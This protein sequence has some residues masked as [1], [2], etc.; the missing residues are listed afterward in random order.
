MKNIREISKADL[1]DIIINEM[2]ESKYRAQQIYDWIWKKNVSRFEDM[3]NLS[4]SLQAALALR[5]FFR[6]LSI[7]SMQESVDGTVKYKFKTSDQHFIEG[8]LIPTEHR[9]TACISSQ[10][11]CSLSC[12]FCATG[13]MGHIRN[14]HF[15]EIYEQV[16]LINKEVEKKYG[17]K[18]TNLVLMGMGEPLLNYKEVL[19]AINYITQPDAFAMSP[20]RITLSTAGIAKMI[21]Q[22][23]DD[24]VRFK[25][26]LSLHAANDVKR[27]QLMPINE[28]NNLKT[29]A[30]ALNYFYQQTKGEITLEYTL[31]QNFNDTVKDA[32]ELVKFY[33]TVP[34]D[35]INIIEYNTI[36]NG[37]FQP[38]SEDTLE[39]FV[40]I[41]SKQQVNV[42]VRR[43][44]GKDIAAACGQLVV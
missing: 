20:R 19:K 29:L 2:G 21:K 31:L 44:R 1:N 26:A 22:L 25:L 14:L 37:I 3:T 38:S 30:T 15:D 16:A 34:V 42:R 33:R 9:K 5:F 17:C 28:H 4:K 10:I 39:R 36:K 18:L 27:S 41:L 8:V 12:K 11:G 24:Q 7:D 35:L 6:N 43:S 40:G 23:G 13:K 32:E